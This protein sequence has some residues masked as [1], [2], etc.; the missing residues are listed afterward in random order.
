Q[1][2]RVELSAAGR[3]RVRE[4]AGESVAGLTSDRLFTAVERAIRVERE[5]IR[6]RHYVVR[7][8]QIVIVDEFTGRLAEGR[9]WRGGLHQAVEAHEAL[10]V[11]PPTSP[12]ARINVQEFFTRYP[13]LAGMTGTA[14]S[15]TAEF[16]TFYR[17][18]VAEIPTH[19]PGRREVLPTRLLP[20][21][22]AKAQAV[23]EETKAMHDLGRPVLIG[24]RSIDKSEQLSA[25]F[26]AAG[27]PHEVLHARRIAQ[28]A[29]L[30][31]R[32]GELGRV[33][34][35]TNMAG[36]GTDI[37]L[38]P[39]V[40]ALGGLHVIGTELHDASRIDRQLFGRCAR[41]GDPG[42]CR[43]FLSLDDELLDQSLGGA[44]AN[45]LRARQQNRVTGLD[46][47][48]GLFRRAQRR[49]ERRQFRDRQLL[50][51]HAKMRR[52]QLAPLGYDPFLDI[53]DE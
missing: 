40:S 19:V 36:R 35:A 15:A 45:R 24:T 1:E 50:V 4:T 29:E 11:T 30:I 32:A 25:L 3:A 44:A 33:T 38:G 14:R 43:Q 39:G 47:L 10:T 9:Q 20:T 18:M 16:R 21:A 52:E 13:H 51:H 46:A 41:Q 49:L 5:L 53:A 12:A 2:H 26:T 37:A 28:E 31:A 17:R 27:L 34:I 7:D 42:S 23:L 22:A 48:T 8:E 6:D